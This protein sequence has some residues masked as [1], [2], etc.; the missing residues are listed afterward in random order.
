[1]SEFRYGD[2][3]PGRPSLNSVVFKIKLFL[4]FSDTFDTRTHLILMNNK[5]I[6]DNCI[7]STPIHSEKYS[8]QMLKMTSMEHYH[9][10][11]P[12]H[13]GGRDGALSD[14]APKKEKLVVVI[15]WT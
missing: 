10:H 5:T 13:P 4:F 2:R 6:I 7:L 3:D 14:M 11:P 15:R 12:Q 1:M 8:P 9:D